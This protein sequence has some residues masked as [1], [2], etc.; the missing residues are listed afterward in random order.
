MPS[1]SAPM[2]VVSAR[3]CMGMMALLRLEKES[4]AHSRRRVR[5]TRP[6]EEEERDRQIER[7]PG[8]AVHECR[9]VGARQVE[10]LAGH[11]ASERHAEKRAHDD[12][13]HAGAC[14]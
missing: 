3:N 8:D 12:E 7:V 4:Y 5:P 13:A 2:C 9:S 10:H 11:P 6:E 1:T 14:F